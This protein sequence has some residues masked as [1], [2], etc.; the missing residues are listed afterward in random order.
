MQLI[1]TVP[2]KF[3]LLHLSIQFE[4]GELNILNGSSLGGFYRLLLLPLS[5]SPG[6]LYITLV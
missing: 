1:A 5:I 2:T 6:I 4:F 3:M